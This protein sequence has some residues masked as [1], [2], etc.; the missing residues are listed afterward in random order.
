M[1]RFLLPLLLLPALLFAVQWRTWEA[2]KAEAGKAHKPILVSFVRDGCHYCHDMEVQVFDDPGMS[3][4]VERCFVPVKVNLSEQSAPF[5]AR[6]PMTP[7]FVIVRA[8]GGIVK[9]IPGSWNIPDFKALAAPA[10][11]KE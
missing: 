7:T 5:E 3:A 11:V 1:S 9:T 8:D 10:C 4:W 2:G 6:I